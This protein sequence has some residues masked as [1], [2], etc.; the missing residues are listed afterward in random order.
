MIDDSLLNIIRN[1][2][3]V[4]IQSSQS[5]LIDKLGVHT[6]ISDN[7]I[8]GNGVNISLNFTKRRISSL[9]DADGISDVPPPLVEYILYVNDHGNVYQNEVSCNLNDNNDNRYKE[10]F[11]LIKYTLKENLKSQV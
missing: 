1:L 2:T 5:T 10:L 7:V 6:R 3:S 8:I 4:Q 9:A 11:L